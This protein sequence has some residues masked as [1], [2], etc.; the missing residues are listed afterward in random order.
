MYMNK[1]TKKACIEDK[2]L[3]IARDRVSSKGPSACYKVLKQ[4]AQKLPKLFLVPKYHHGSC[5]TERD[6]L[7]VD[8]LR[9][10]FARAFDP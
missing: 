1:M 4:A 9:T 5:S 8:K 10:P 6:Y 7:K 2:F 3:S